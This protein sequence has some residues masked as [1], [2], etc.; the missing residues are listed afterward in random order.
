VL[1]IREEDVDFEDG[2]EA[3]PGGG[4]DRGQV[5]DALMLCEFTGLV[6]WC[7]M[8]D[9]LD[10]MCMWMLGAYGAVGDGARDHRHR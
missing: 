7:W 3:A 5:A 4:E 10:V 2:I 1:H 8:M 9:I 6:F